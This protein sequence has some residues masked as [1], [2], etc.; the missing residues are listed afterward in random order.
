MR[1]SLWLFVIATSIVCAPHAVA[2]KALQTE[3]DTRSEAIEKQVITW[4]RDIHQH[5]ELSNRE[6]RTGK[7]VAEHL[8]GLG[9]LVKTEVAHTGVVGLLKG[10]QPGPVVA[11]RADMDALPVA[12]ETGLPFASKVK[13]EYNGQEVGVMHACG[14]DHHVA[15]LMGVAQVLAGMKEQLP[16]TVKFI[17][18]PAEEGAPPGEQGGA[19]LMVKEGVLDDPRPEAIFGL[20]V[21]PQWEVGQVAYRAGGMMASSDRMR[22]VVRGKQTHGAKPWLGT[23]PI[24]VASQIVMALQTVASRQ[25][26]VTLAPAIVTVGSIHGGLRYNIIPD[27]VEMLGTIRAFDA[28]MRADIHE[29]VKRTVAKVAESA[30]ATAEVE[31]SDGTPVTYNDP[32]L[33][34]KMTPTF[35]RVLGDANVFETQR[36]TWAEDFSEYQKII[37]GFYFYLGVRTPDAERALFPPNHSPQFRADEGALLVGVRA[38]ANLAVDY[39][40][41]Q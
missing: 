8:K 20:H 30:G 27:E 12:E 23:D 21:I 33:V 22:I 31:I 25:I 9:L 29:R 19:D 3:I 40:H 39:M 36:Q 16:G 15:I 11:L 38:L 10:G 32:A 2:N 7:L 1:L 17:F 24:V 41:M 6:F 37:P 34:Q 14:H 4:R 28:D 5:P 13:G 18:Q 26:D 35:H